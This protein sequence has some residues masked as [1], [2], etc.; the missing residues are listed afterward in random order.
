VG[1]RTQATAFACKATN[2][3]DIKFIKKILKKLCQFPPDF[4][5]KMLQVTTYE[6]HN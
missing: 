5:D 3:I 1:N 2:A 6:K 4:I